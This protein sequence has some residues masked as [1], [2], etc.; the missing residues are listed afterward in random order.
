MWFNSD[1]QLKLN[2][3]SCFFKSKS[4]DG[5][6]YHSK[7]NGDIFKRWTEEQ[8]IP[9][10]SP[11]SVVV[12]DNASYHS[13]QVPGTKAPTSA[14]RKADMQSWLRD[15]GVRVDVKLKKPQLYTLIQKEEENIRKVFQVDELLAEKGNTVVR[16]PHTT[17]ISI[18]LI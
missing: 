5:R 14:T 15:R 10:L 17:V 8:V 13:V 9:A 6:N 16:L 18:L 11:G 7:M 1:W 3:L 12:M 2:I 4:N